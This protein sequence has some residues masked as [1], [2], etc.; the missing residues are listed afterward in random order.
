MSWVYDDGG[1]RAAGFKGDTGDCVIRAIAIAT[2]TPYATLYQNVQDHLRTTYPML[3]QAG[4][5]NA[6]K[7]LKK[8]VYEPL[9][10]ELGFTWTPTMRIGQ[11]C[12]VH[13]KADEL[14]SGRLIVRVTRHLTA[15]IDGVLHDTY[16]PSR[17]GTRCVYGYWSKA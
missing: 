15:M 8:A 16:D 7:G 5:V 1:R 6:R 4:K 9:L 2:E 10:D 3:W 14:P 12:K 17:G 13:L 11:G